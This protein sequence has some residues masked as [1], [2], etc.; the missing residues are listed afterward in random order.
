M[1]SGANVNSFF[2]IAT[3]VISIPTGAKVF[4]W[5]FTMYRGRIRYE[6]PM[7]WV[8]AFMFTFV[9]GG[10]TGVLLAV[11]PADFV[12]H[13]SLFLVAHF[14]NVIIGGVLFGLLAGIVYWFPKA[15]GFKLDPFWGKVGFWGWLI[16]YWVAWTPMYVVGLMGVPR[17]VNHI[18]DVSLQPYFVV[19]AI[20]AAIIALGIFG[21]IMSIVMGI[22]NRDKLRDNTG[23]PWGGRT[24]EWSTSSP[25]PAYNFAFTPIVHTND[26]WYDMQ[27]RGY[28]RPVDGFRPIHMPHNTGVGV[29]LSFLAL[30]FGFGMIWYI[31]WMAAISFVGIIGLSIFHTF[32]Y[33]RDYFIPKDDVV[34]TEGERTALLAKGA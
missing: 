30:T 32:N 23:D 3:M 27:T 5:L 15:Y 10:M 2:G 1:G 13:N 9:V 20:G 12:L 29:I 24:L 33:N 7:M 6:L 4:N 18:D 22:K 21:F 34:R 8:I 19:A 17:R 26:A 16:G 11:P 28:V 14:H 31:W 25:P